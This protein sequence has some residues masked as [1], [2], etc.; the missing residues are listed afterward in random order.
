MF[1]SIFNL[2]RILVLARLG[3]G[4]EPRPCRVIRTSCAACKFPNPITRIYCFCVCSAKVSG[5][6]ARF[7]GLGGSSTSSTK[8]LRSGASFLR[9]SGYS[10]SSVKVSGVALWRQ[11]CHG[12]RLECQLPEARRHQ[13]QLRQGLQLWPQL[14]QTQ[15]AGIS[16]AKVSSSGTSFLRLCGPSASTAKVSDSSVSFFGFCAPAPALPRSQDPRKV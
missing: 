1:K 6:G 5:S 8:V 16:S 11:L 3:Q 4:Q 2:K 12:L 15:W 14:P 9:L 7:L 10:A 13:P